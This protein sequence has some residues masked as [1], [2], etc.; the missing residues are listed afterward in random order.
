MNLRIYP[1]VQWHDAASPCEWALLDD[2]GNIK[3]SGSS[4]MALMPKADE[5]T[6]IL[7]AG[8]VLAASVELPKIKRRKLEAALPFALEEML[9]EDV[10]DTHVT[11]G[12]RCADGKTVLYAIDRPWLLRFLSA[13]AAA[14]LRIRRIVPEYCLLPAQQDEWG[15]VWDGEQGFMAQQD[16][17]GCALDR[18]DVT[19]PPAILKLLL[20]QRSPKALR[21]YKRGSETAQPNWE[22]GVPLVDDGQ[23]FDWRKARLPEAGCNLLWGKLA[24]PPRISE[25]LPYL[26]PAFMA[27]L[28]LFVVEVAFSNIEWASLAYERHRLDAQMA[29]TFQETF[30]KD[31]VIVDAPLQMQRNVTQLRHAVGVQDSS[32]FIPLLER[33]SSATGRI[34][35]LR[36]RTLR[37]TDNRLDLELTTQTPAVKVLMESLAEAGVSAKLL[38]RRDAGNESVL[39][40]QLSAGGVR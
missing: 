27:A 28:L 39:Q 21:I 6:V 19:R 24:P 15:L 20:R 4:T 16:G 11:P 2:Q 10:K 34:Q 3:E 40:L 29:Q 9:I 32:D 23:R 30:G 17:L 1:D 33:F 38:E 13:A 14:K 26:R 12:A 5:A 37:Y 18:G 31:A 22:L 7:S 35:N 25:I 8:S 36:I